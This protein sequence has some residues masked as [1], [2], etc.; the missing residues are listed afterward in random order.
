MK[1]KGSQRKFL[2]SLAHH[3]KPQV[4]VGKN[5]LS[6]SAISFINE[7]L[8][9]HELI[10]VKFDDN[11]YKNVEKEKIH[12]SINC[13]IVGDIG[14]ILILYRYQEDDDLRKIELPN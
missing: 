1:L 12:D 14:K 2:R 5:K 9:I 11:K 10:K 3:L 13:H 4:V 6:N 7:L 8:S